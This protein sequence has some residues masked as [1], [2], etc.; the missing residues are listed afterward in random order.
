M[1]EFTNVQKHKYV[2][3]KIRAHPFYFYQL[4]VYVVFL[5]IMYWIVFCPVL[6]WIIFINVG[7]SSAWSVPFFISS[8]TLYLVIIG[9]FLCIWRCKGHNKYKQENEYQNRN[10]SM[11]L[12]ASNKVNEEKVFI[13]LRPQRS[14]KDSTCSC[15]Q[16][17]CSK[18]SMNRK[19]KTVRE[20]AVLQPSSKNES[21]GKN[22]KSTSINEECEYFIAHVHSPVLCKTE[23]FL[24]VDD[25]KDEQKPFEVRVSK[26]VLD[27]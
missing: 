2:P 11:Y 8:I 14:S 7:H 24:F 16:N 25:S 6:Y 23:M 5:S 21:A 13:S 18:C 17:N 12:G 26:E 4:P 9:I 27:G 19:P 20:M 3:H 22:P 10:D 15:N 1:V